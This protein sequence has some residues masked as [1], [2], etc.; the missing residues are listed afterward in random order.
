MLPQI[1]TLFDPRSSALNLQ[2]GSMLE[3]H[4]KSDKIELQTVIRSLKEEN[5]NY[6]CDLNTCQKTLSTTQAELENAK[7]SFGYFIDISSVFRS[8]SIIYV[9]SMTF[10]LYDKLISYKFITFITYII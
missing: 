1:G 3:N 4:K 7:L 8:I 2:V 5:L 9:V 10:G 6:S